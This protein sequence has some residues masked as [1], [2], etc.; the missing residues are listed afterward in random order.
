M[1]ERNSIRPKFKNVLAFGIEIRINPDDCIIKYKIFVYFPADF[2]ITSRI[3]PKL[4]YACQKWAMD[5][6]FRACALIFFTGIILAPLNQEIRQNTDFAAEIIKNYNLSVDEFL[7]SIN[8][9]IDRNGIFA[10]PMAVKLTDLT[11]LLIKKEV[12]ADLRC[13][14]FT[15]ENLPEYSL[16]QVIEMNKLSHGTIKSINSI[17]GDCL[18]LLYRRQYFDLET[19]ERLFERKPDDPDFMHHILRSD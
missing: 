11:V 8:V 6:I 17:N 2:T 14:T 19:L 4:R 12:V 1:N 13:V 3:Y 10:L 16:G 5:S 9:D 18:H 7:S 15:F